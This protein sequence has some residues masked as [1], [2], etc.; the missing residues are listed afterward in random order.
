M[1]A[2][3]SAGIVFS[4][5]VMPAMHAGGQTEPE[6][7][8]RKEELPLRHSEH[9]HTVHPGIDRGTLTFATFINLSLAPFTQR[10]RKI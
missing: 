10:F 9:I 1:C 8:E 4:F 2:L 5:E 7:G 6:T 3:L